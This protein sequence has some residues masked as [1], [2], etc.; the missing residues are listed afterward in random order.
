MATKYSTWNRGQDEALLNKLG[1]QEVAERILTCSSVN[2][3]FSD[4]K[5]EVVATD[6]VTS[7]WKPITIGN[8]SRD[9]LI[10]ILKERGINVGDWVADMMKQDAFTVAQKEEQ[11]DLVN[12]S[13]AELGFDKA[14]RYDAICARAKERGLELCP[15]EVGPQ[16]RLQYL[17]QPLGEWIRVAMEAIRD[18]GGLLRVFSVGHRDD[19]LWLSSFYGKPDSLWFPGYRFVFRARKPLDT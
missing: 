18:S 4:S 5:A 12:V 17:D 2:V 1:G 8:I 19:G 13:V 6:P 16:L 10:L 3:T 11:I 9:K 15:P 7:I 14:T